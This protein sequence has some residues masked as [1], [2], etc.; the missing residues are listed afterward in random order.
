VLNKIIPV[1][2]E[3][4]FPKTYLE[5]FLTACSQIEFEYKLT[6]RPQLHVQMFYPFYYKDTFVKD[7]IIELKERNNKNVARLFGKILA[8]W[9]M[10]KAEEVRAGRRS[11]PAFYLT[12][13]PQHISKTKEKGFCHTTTLTHAIYLY[14]KKVYPDTQLRLRSCIVKKSKTK[15]LHNT[16]GKKKRFSIIKNSM[17]AHI[18]KQDALNSYF[19]L[20]D[21]VYTTGATFKEA[22]RSLLNCGVPSEH[23]F[24]I[25]IAH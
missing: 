23:I 14:I 13:I 6:S 9:I 19:F 12:P 8:G 15:N 1:I 20:I 7:C 4:I 16:Q 25:S 17:H 22:R 18:T 11:R 2:I 3:I 24:F 10:R 5:S 21:D